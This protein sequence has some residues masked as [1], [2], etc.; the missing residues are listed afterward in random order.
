VEEGS[1]AG[2]YET[3]FGQFAGNNTDPSSATITWDGAPDPYITCPTCFLI[4]KDG[5][6]T[7]SQY[8]FSLNGWNGQETIS[9]INFWPGNV[10]GAISNVAIWGGNTASSSTTGGQT[11]SGNQVS[12]PGILG[13]LGLGLIGQVFLLRQR[14]RRL[15]K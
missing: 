2:Y 4:V 5:A 15:Q 1:A 8:L 12:E 13:L 11:T 10:T 6:G 9:L 14:R 3:V 7:P